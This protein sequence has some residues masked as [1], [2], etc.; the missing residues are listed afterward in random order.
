MRTDGT[1]VDHVVVFSTA[2]VMKRDIVI[3]TSSVMGQAND[4]LQ[5][6][7]EGGAGEPMLIGHFHEDHYQSLDVGKLHYALNII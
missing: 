3:V 4:N 1:Y 7:V 6:I 5:T 2:K